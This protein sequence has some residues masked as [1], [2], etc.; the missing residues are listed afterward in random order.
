MSQLSKIDL[1]FSRPAKGAGCM[2]PLGLGF[3]VMGGVWLWLGVLQPWIQSIDSS[4]WVATPCRI[5]KCE[6]VKE[7]D[8]KIQAHLEIHYTYEYAGRQYKSS[9]F[10][11]HPDS[12]PLAV[13]SEYPVG[14]HATCWVDPETP[15]EAALR[16]QWSPGFCLFVLIPFG[17]IPALVGVW[18]ISTGFRPWWPHHPT[19]SQ[20]TRLISPQRKSLAEF[21]MSIVVCMFWNGVLIAFTMKWIEQIRDQGLQWGDC[22]AIFLVLFFG[23]IGLGIVMWVIGTCRDLVRSCVK[24]LIENGAIVQTGQPLR[25]RCIG[26]K[27]PLR[28][29]LICRETANWSG[30]GSKTY[31]DDVMSI[32]VGELQDDGE[33][34]F[35]VPEDLMPSFKSQCH[36]IEWRLRLR[37]LEDPEKP[38]LD[39]S[40]PVV[41]IRGVPSCPN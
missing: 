39:D 17:L 29:E 10:D 2:I 36:R 40:Y 13:A 23:L 19:K 27:Q 6:V 30:R 21:L 5:V 7:K 15:A 31:E 1:D 9:R 41:V 26:V 37:S 11:F 4:S 33:L 24:I 35:E 12:T 34:R 14:A 16:R 20:Q 8:Q 32:A 25:L 3:L 38:A 28:L 22:L 18:L